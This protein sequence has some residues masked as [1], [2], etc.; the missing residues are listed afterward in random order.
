LALAANVSALVTSSSPGPTLAAKA[1][2][3]RA[4]VPEENATANGTSQTAANSSSNAATVGP[5]VS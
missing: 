3:C 4:A 2:A 5:W 1:A